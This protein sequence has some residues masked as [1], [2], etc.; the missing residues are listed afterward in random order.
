MIC[1]LFVYTNRLTTTHHHAEIV[2]TG[3]SSYI[4]SC[5]CAISRASGVNHDHSHRSEQLGLELSIQVR[6]GL[7]QLL[8]QIPTSTQLHNLLVVV[9][10]AFTPCHAVPL[11][12]QGRYLPCFCRRERD[13]ARSNTGSRTN[14][15]KT[16][17]P[18]ILDDSCR[19]QFSELVS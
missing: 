8:D 12:T 19:F 16:C 9:Y 2:N 10:L 1:T 17:T 14:Y 4:G 6:P 13:S 18:Y 15:Y 5:L 7:L 11:K 3:Y